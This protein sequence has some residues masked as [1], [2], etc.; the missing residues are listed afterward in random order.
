MDL[1]WEK[2]GMIGIDAGLCWIG[3][4]CYVLHGQNPKE[5]GKDW[6]EFCSILE[7]AEEDN[8][9]YNF[10]I[11][12]VCVTTGYGDGTYPVFVKRNSE[13]RISEVKV[14]FI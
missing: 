3:D 14:K 9:V 6:D 2:I 8:G 1:K 7:A 10:D 5:I 12:G 13:G 4:P 11:T